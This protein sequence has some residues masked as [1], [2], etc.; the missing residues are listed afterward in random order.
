MLSK[1]EEPSLWCLPTFIIPKKLLPG[2]TTPRVRWVSD[3]RELNKVVKPVQ[4]QLPQINEVLK[5][6][7]GYE[8]FSKLDVSMQFYTFELDDKSK[9]LCTVATPFGN[10]R[11]N[12]VPMGLKIS[13]A[14]AQA[15]ME[16]CLR[17]SETSDVYIDDVGIFDDDW[18]GHLT[19]LDLV[20]LD[21]RRTVSPV[22]L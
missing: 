4:Y 17:D 21:W 5:K 13:P 1:V 18:A 11:Y 22:I 19:S 3:L 7:R 20:F 9:E 16:Q 10:Y 6:R 12:R 14:F 2:E 15:K 8:F